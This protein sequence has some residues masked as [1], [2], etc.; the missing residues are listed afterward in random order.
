[1]LGSDVILF[2][3]G[4]AFLHLEDGLPASEVVRNPTD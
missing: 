1:M 2:I 3:V 4:V